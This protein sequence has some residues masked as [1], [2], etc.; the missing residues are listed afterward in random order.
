[1]F[2]DHD[3]NFDLE[4]IYDET[5]FPLESPEGVFYGEMAAALLLVL[6]GFRQPKEFQ[7]LSDSELKEVLERFL[8][9]LESAKAELPNAEDKENLHNYY[10]DYFCR[11]KP[12]E[13]SRPR[14]L[15][16]IQ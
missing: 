16:L 15:G 10:Q 1:M 3:Q 9:F 2:Y 7:T 8:S 12:D 4:R 13:T 11:K 6:F 5:L 14:L